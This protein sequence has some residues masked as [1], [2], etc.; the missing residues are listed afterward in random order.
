MSIA[1][2]M[3]LCPTTH[4]AQAEG[5]DVLLYSTEL[6]ARSLTHVGKMYQASWLSERLQKPGVLVSRCF[7]DSPSVQCLLGGPA[8]TSGSAL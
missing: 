3:L 8:V 7:C 5:N 6:E 1:A 2:P 4:G